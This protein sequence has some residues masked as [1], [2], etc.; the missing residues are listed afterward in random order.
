MRGTIQNV[1]PGKGN[2]EVSNLKMVFATSE[3]ATAERAFERAEQ[4]LWLKI[5]AIDGAQMR[6]V[7]HSIATR[8]VSEKTLN[9]EDWKEQIVGE[10]STVIVSLLATVTIVPPSTQP[11]T[12]APGQRGT[13]R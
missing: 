8:T 2:P 1:L 13:G 5:K 12:A 4:A 6:T 10:N 3:A 7:E 11:P 9:L